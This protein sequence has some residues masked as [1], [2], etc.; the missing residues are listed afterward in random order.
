MRNE[1]EPQAGSRMRI[2]ETSFGGNF[3]CWDCGFM[4]S[5]FWIF[6]RH[7]RG[8]CPDRVPNGIFHNVIHDIG[9]RVINPACLLDLRLVFHNRAMAIGQSDDFAQKLLIHLPQYVGRQN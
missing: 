6:I 3:L 7:S 1:P 5:P 8:F 4:C 2:L 9:R